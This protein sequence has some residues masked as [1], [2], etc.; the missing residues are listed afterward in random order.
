MN[1]K[2]IPDIIRA[3]VCS[4]QVPLICMWYIYVLEWQLTKITRNDSSF[5]ETKWKTYMRKHMEKGGKAK[6]KTNIKEWKER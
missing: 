6:K 1:V 4:F 5:D 3:A 2:Y